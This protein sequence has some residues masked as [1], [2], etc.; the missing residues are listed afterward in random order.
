[1]KSI[2]IAASVLA[3]AS[4]AA[5]GGGGGS[6]TTSEIVTFE[7]TAAKGILKSA[8]VQAYELVNG[9]LTKYGTP[10]TTDETGAFKLNLNKTS[11]PVIVK[12]TTNINTKMLDETTITTDGKFAQISAPSDLVL[13]TMVADLN[14]AANSQANP[15]TDMAIAGALNAKDASGAAVT[16]TKDVLL[17]SKEA[18]KTQ[19]GINPFALKAVDAN[20]TTASVDQKKLMTLLTGVAKAAKDDSTCS[21]F[22]QVTKLGDKAEIK[23]DKATGKGS[24]KDSLGMAAK[25]NETSSKASTVPSPMVIALPTYAVVKETDVASGAEVI[26]RDSFETFVNVMRDG[27][28]TARTALDKS[29]KTVDD[30]TKDLTF[31]TAKAGLDAF[32]AATASCRFPDT[33][34]ICEG[35]DVKVV[36]NGYELT[37]TSAGYTN[38]VTA[39]GTVVNGVGNLNVTGSSSVISTNKK[40]GE[41]SVSATVTGLT[42]SNTSPDSALLNISLTG[43][44]DATAK[45]VTVSLKDINVKLDNT[46]N[47]MTASGSLS[48]NNSYNDKLTG[49]LDLTMV[50][51]GPTVNLMEGY[52]TSASLNVTGY[53][54][55]KTLLALGIGATI[56]Y[57]T[58]KPWIAESSSNSGSATA[59]VKLAFIN[60]G[61]KLDITAKQNSY[62]NV[63]MKVVFKS[64]LNSITATSNVMNAVVKEVLFTSSSGDFTAK[65]TKDTNGA[66]TGVIKQGNVQVGTI[67]GGLIKVNGKELSL[68]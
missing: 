31:T 61:V 21:T 5:C 6:P 20:D 56:D 33:T 35:K 64:G 34:L 65:L 58:Y 36:A 38:K 28:N 16:L 51:L 4:L 68:N 54:D 7:G 46:K 14:T 27:L 17:I 23:Y 55:D 24:F 41:L 62:Q 11:N 2:R 25:L 42:A 22:C 49:T 60:E 63:D 40:A 26:A 19:L 48:I 8:D 29:I 52:V 43:Y 45:P 12:I 30:R 47:T 57:T 1:M 67:E 44:D 3:I 39:S 37:Y 18:V 32:N 10:T 53:G 50:K 15:F 66:T 9:A 59:N 13:R